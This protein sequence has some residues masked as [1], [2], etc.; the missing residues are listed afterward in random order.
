VA[1]LEF[2]LGLT[3]VLG[4]T[5]ECCLEVSLRVFAVFLGSIALLFEELE[6]ALPKRLFAV[7]SIEKVL[8]HTLEFGVLLALLL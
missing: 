4:H 6:F 8:I 5:L 7:V 1:I 3:G 2:Q